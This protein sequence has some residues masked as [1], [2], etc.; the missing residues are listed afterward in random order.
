MMLFVYGS[1]KRGEP[2]NDKI[3]GSFIKKAILNRYVLRE[4]FYTWIEQGEGFVEGELFEVDDFEELDKFEDPFERVLVQTNEGEAF[5]Y[6][7][8]P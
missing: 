4:G 2:N 3:K 6:I 8:L 5:C 1:L 7:I